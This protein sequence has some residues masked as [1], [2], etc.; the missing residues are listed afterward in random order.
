MVTSTDTDA[1]GWLTSLR[2]SVEPL[3][4]APIFLLALYGLTRVPRRVAV[5]SVTLLAYQWGLAIIFV[6]ATRYRIPWDFVAA[7]LAGAALV[8]LAERFGRRR[9]GRAAGAVAMLTA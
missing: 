1:I 3:F 6:G 9:A 7:L 2:D 4:V 8:D 5:L